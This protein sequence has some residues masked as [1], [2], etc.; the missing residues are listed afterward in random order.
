MH[1][2]LFQIGS[3]TV[4]TYGVCIALGLIAAVTLAYYRSQEFGLNADYM[5][6]GGIIAFVFG[7]IGAKLLYIIV[8]FKSYMADPSLFLQFGSGFVVYGGLILGI[9]AYLIYFRIKRVPVL[10]YLEIA[11]PAVSLGQALGRVGCVM[12][13]CCYGKVCPEDAWYAL[14]FPAGTEGMAGVPL[15]PVQV[16][17]VIL[18]LILCAILIWSNY[19]EKLAGL[20]FS[21][22]LTLYSAGRFLIEFLRN[23]PRG[24]VGPLSTSQFISIF[25][26]I[27]GVGAFFVFRWYKA[28]PVKVGGYPETKKEEPSEETE[29]EKLAAEAV[30][31]EAEAVVKEEVS[32]DSEAVTAADL[33]MN[34]LSEEF[35][36][37]AEKKENEDVL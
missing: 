23:D 14:H 25:T 33:L 13:G 10:Q 18:N 32:D 7:M 28:D 29:E 37:M 3:V 6:N 20:S 4:Y 17:C 34:E 27:I 24:F 8:E 26:F 35:A 16:M 5:F 12:A 15:Y 31:E 22:Y 2:V 11:V 19:K 21:L 36:N 9:A 1:R 30:V